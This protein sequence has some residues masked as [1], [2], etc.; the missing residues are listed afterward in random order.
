MSPGSDRAREI[1]ARSL[2]QAGRPNEALPHWQALVENRPDAVTCLAACALEAGEV[3]LAQASAHRVLAEDP[4]SIDGR[5]L[6]GKALVAHGEYEAARDHLEKASREAPEDPSVWIALADCQAQAGDDQAAGSTL[7]SASQVLPDHA[8]IQ[9]ALARW[10]KSQGRLSEALEA[11]HK[12]V[13][14][15]PQEPDWLVEY[16]VLLQA[17][18]HDDQALPV[19]RAAVSRRPGAW[20]ARQALALAYEARREWASAARL[21]EQVPQSA[22]AEA[23]FVAGRIVIEAATAKGM[24]GEPSRGLDLLEQAKSKGYSHPSVHLWTGR[25]HE[26]ASD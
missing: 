8:Q 1:L 20:E 18:G 9:A 26:L 4:R 6:L 12:A 24:S 23:H 2:Q 16:G 3:E 15:E 14:L 25:A 17:L 21:L 5:V 11:A 13:Q 22:S 10:L 7:A 19:L